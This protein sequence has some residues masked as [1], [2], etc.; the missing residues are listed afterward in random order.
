MAVP[1]LLP[2]D[3]VPKLPHSFVFLKLLVLVPVPALVFVITF[4]SQA[5]PNPITTDMDPS[6]IPPPPPPWAPSPPSCAKPWRRPQ[7]VA[8][9]REAAAQDDIVGAQQQ[10]HSLLHSP[11][12]ASEQNKPV[13]TWLYGSLV[14]ATERQN[15]DIIQ[16]LLSEHVSDGELP[17]ECAVRGRAFLVTELFLKLGC[18]INRPIGSQRPST[19]RSVAPIFSSTL[20]YGAI[21]FP[22]VA[23]TGTWSSGFLIMVQTPT[24]VA[25]WIAHPCLWQWFTLLSI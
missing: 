18:D 17:F 4:R 5:T 15:L 8:L 22:S 11:R 6:S 19:L 25:T 21:A 7:E 10:V 14:V 20:T 1:R 2:D 3:S 16:F 24:V 13:P 9:C 12:P 23:P